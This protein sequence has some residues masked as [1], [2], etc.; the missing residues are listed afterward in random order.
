MAAR[1]DI[2]GKLNEIENEPRPYLYSYGFAYIAL[3]GNER[4]NERMNVQ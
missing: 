3:Y 2:Y 1:N 4:M